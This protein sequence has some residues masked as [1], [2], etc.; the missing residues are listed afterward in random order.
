MLLYKPQP[1][2]PQKPVK[3]LLGKRITSVDYFNKADSSGIEDPAM[4]VGQGGYT[5]DQVSGR[6]NTKHGG[7]FYFNYGEDL[8]SRNVRQGIRK[9]DK[10]A[11]RYGN[12][13]RMGF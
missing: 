1:F 3:G 10:D 4:A 5:N 7:E 9:S 8:N 12:S 2:N 11:K 13:F 6:L